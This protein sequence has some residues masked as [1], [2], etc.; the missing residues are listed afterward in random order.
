MAKCK[1][2]TDARGNRC[3]VDSTESAQ[4]RNTENTDQS[5]NVRGS[6]HCEKMVLER[7]RDL[8]YRVC[9][10]T[11]KRVAYPHLA[12]S[13]TRYAQHSA[14]LISL[15]TYTPLILLFRCS[16]NGNTIDSQTT[17]LFLPCK[18]YFRKVVKS[19]VC[20]RACVCEKSFEEKKKKRK[21]NFR[22]V[23]HVRH[24]ENN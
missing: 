14:M 10:A 18:G 13:I 24:S 6:D 21:M 15:S 5:G 22:Q 9:R 2:N 4:K 20:A 19:C 11:V 3:C 16:F 1:W 23:K 8:F 17:V 7:S 12:S